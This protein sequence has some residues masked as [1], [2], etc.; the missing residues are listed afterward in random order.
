VK[1]ITRTELKQGTGEAKQEPEEKDWESDKNG[2][3]QT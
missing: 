3:H 1:Q 2:I